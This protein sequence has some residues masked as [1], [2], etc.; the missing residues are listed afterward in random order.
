MLESELSPD[1]VAQLW[2]FVH[3]A[4]MDTGIRQ[5][6]RSFLGL[7]PRHTWGYAVVEIE[8]WQSGAGFRGGHQPF[9]VAILYEGLLDQVA[10][11][12][13]KPGRLLHRNPRSALIPQ[14]TCYVCDLLHN[15]GVPGL[16]QM[17]TGYAGSRSADLAAEANQLMYTTA[18]CRETRPRWEAKVC[19]LCAQD[20]GGSPADA[21]EHC[22]QLCRQHL[23]A[24]DAVTLE[25]SQ[26]V[27]S[28]LR[29]IAVR[30]R[31]LAQSMT[32]DGIPASAQDDSSWIEALGWFAGWNLPL[33]LAS[34]P[35]GRSTRQPSQPAEAERA[36][37]DP[38]RCG[39]GSVLA[40]STAA[41]RHR[42]N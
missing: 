37:G 36:A 14:G 2:S 39:A 31:Q 27:A 26:A 30:L 8:L 29:D 42:N 32:K 21:V 20:L 25:G 1:E 33:A 23:A 38:G 19:R 12:L 28:E 11:A 41:D 24:D 7:C 35:S 22:T 40:A 34:P 16:N 10:D 6:L 18:W 15:P 4:I 13:D 9:D 3:G 17:A 5:R